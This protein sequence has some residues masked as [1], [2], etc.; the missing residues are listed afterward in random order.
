MGQPGFNLQYDFAINGETIIV[1]RNGQELPT[2][3]SSTEKDTKDLVSP[4]S[5]FLQSIGRSRADAHMVCVSVE[6]GQPVSGVFGN[7]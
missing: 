4:L 6:A 5:K 1:K 7:K 2:K 3:F